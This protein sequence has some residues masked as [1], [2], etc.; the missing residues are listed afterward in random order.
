MKKHLHIHVQVEAN[1]RETSDRGGTKTEPECT[2]VKY[3][4]RKLHRRNEVQVHIIASKT[5]RNTNQANLKV[6]SRWKM[7]TK[8]NSNAKRVRNKKITI[9]NQWR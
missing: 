3:K 9:P 7:T 6:T 8:Y 2:K 5:I 4:K 1:K